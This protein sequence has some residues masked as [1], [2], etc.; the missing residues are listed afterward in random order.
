MTKIVF[1]SWNSKKAAEIQKAFPGYEV[2]YGIF[3]K[4]GFTDRMLDIAKESDDILLINEDH[5]IR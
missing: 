2:L 1:A 3:S 4:S 5:L